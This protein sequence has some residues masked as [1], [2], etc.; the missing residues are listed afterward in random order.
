MDTTGH[1]AFWRARNNPGGQ[2]RLKPSAA[3]PIHAGSTI[4]PL[5]WRLS[6]PYAEQLLFGGDHRQNPGT[7]G[8]L[9]ASAGMGTEVAAEV[10]RLCRGWG[11]P[12]PF[13]LQRPALMSFPL[14]ATMP[15]IRGRL[16]AVIRV[17]AG[18]EPLFHAVVLGD[19]L[20][21]AFDRNP[22]LLARHLTFQEQW[23]PGLSP[24]RLEL[25]ADTRE[26]PG[27]MVSGEGDRGLIDEAA[28]QVILGGRLHLPLEQASAE[29]DRALALMITCL[30]ATVRREL[31]FASL[32]TSRANAYTLGALAASGGTIVGW[33]RLLS[34]TPSS[35]ITPDIASYQ[36]AIGQAL[37]AGDLNAIARHSLRH[38]FGSASDGESL[39]TSV[40]EV[41]ADPEP[42]ML[43]TPLSAVVVPRGQVESRSRAGSSA[44]GGSDRLPD[45]S[46]RSARTVSVIGPAPFEPLTPHGAGAGTMPWAAR[47]PGHP[48]RVVSQRPG[49]ARTLAIVIVVFLASGVV[50]LRMNGRT[51]TESLEWAGIPGLS[52]TAGKSEPAKTL[53]EVVDVGGVY[54][55][56]RSALVGAGGGLGPS[57]DQARRKALA[58]LTARAAAPLVAQ[59]DLFV[60]LSADGIQQ[61][62]RPDRETERLRALAR[63]G[64]VLGNELKRLELA[65]YAL[66]ASVLWPDLDALPDQGVVA[67]SDSLTRRDRTALDE[68]R[69]GM[70]LT[71][72]IRE[73]ADA[74]RNIDGMAALVELFQTPSWSPRWAADLRAAAELVSPTTSPLTR[75]YRNCAFQLLR[76]KEAE[77]APA[78]RGLPYA[79]DLAAQSWPSPAIRGLLPD[80]RRAAG[81]FA[82]DGAPTL[83]G[84]ILKLYADLAD[85]VRV[86]G[87]AATDAQVLARL[88]ANPA[89]RFD[90]AVYRP[91]LDRLRYEAATR[92]DGGSDV[93]AREAMRFGRAAGDSRS[94]KQWQALADSLKTPFLAEWARRRAGAAAVVA[95]ERR[96]VRAG[97]L[98]AAREAAADLR[99]AAA[100]G[101]DWSADWRRTSALVTCFLGEASAS[102]DGGDGTAEIVE[103]AASLEQSLPLRLVQ[104]T[105]RLTPAILTQPEVA[106]FEV[107]VPGSDA[108]WRSRAFT[109][110]PAAPA[111]TGW[112]G[113]VDLDWTVPLGARQALTCRVVAADGRRLMDVTAPSLADGG[114]PGTYGRL[115]PVDGGSVHLKVGAG[116]WAALALPAPP[117]VF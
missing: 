3:G 89:F 72:K 88:E 116:W 13:G 68:A 94:A 113:N 2:F 92:R 1:F 52:G 18:I 84:G 28:V 63:Q 15:S 93:L 33:R 64:D 80:L 21:V 12:P 117:V 25:E 104:A 57:L 107:V 4:H 114:G 103:V 44:Q 99:R 50:M 87:Q 11:D 73:L 53:L 30:P 43:K 81:A 17:G 49:L 96:D 26:F 66:A 109:V 41:R 77:R 38:E 108:T 115:C 39:V 65:W 61:G 9:G 16:Y 46:L 54:E 5:A 78:S 82:R 36:V 59:I 45:Q 67:R 31:R 97:Q 71:H 62:S 75:A 35:G 23:R 111:G 90:A 85:P 24:P 51:L 74:R 7:R 100:E 27:A 14:A 91:Y 8:V 32:A 34:S 101:I 37:A 86:A 48:R 98:V 22:Y 20:Y 76:I 95:G 42:K 83:I 55:D 6:L 47:Q 19:G 106:V 40:T 102:G 60:T 105:I 58:N 69:T 79:V 10:E 112:V 29:S 56:Q 70:G 110:G